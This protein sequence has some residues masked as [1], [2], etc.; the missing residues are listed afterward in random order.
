MC[1]FA[2]CSFLLFK[3]FKWKINR[4]DS[5]ADRPISFT[6]RYLLCMS[7]Y[8]Y[9]HRH[10]LFDFADK[11]VV[12]VNILFMHTIHGDGFANANLFNQCIQK[13]RCQFGRVGLLLDERNPCFHIDILSLQ[14]L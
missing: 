4:S 6:C 5:G 7:A 2:I 10:S 11:A 9:L 13:R 1:A 3:N 14:F 12:D 8:A